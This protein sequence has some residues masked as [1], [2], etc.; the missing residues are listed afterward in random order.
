MNKKVILEILKCL[1]KYYTFGLPNFQKSYIGETEMRN[2]LTRKI[3]DLQAGRKSNWTDLVDALKNNV[4]GVLLDQAYYQFPSYDA[5]IEVEAQAIASH[6]LTTRLILSISLLGPFYTAYF[7]D[8]FKA[9]GYVT[10]PKR[11]PVWRLYYSKKATN[12]GLVSQTL[13]AVKKRVNHFFDGYK[14]VPHNLLL[15]YKISNA[16]PFMES[17][18]IAKPEYPIYNFLFNAGYGNAEVQVLE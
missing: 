14:F 8:T 2:I 9:G 5:V 10:D 4:P 6:A 7:E 18:E 1:E 12:N 13:D 3:D 15:T 16:V 17:I 11:D